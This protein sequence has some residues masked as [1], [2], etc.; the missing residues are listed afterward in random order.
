MKKINTKIEGVFVIE[1]RVFE[2]PRGFFM[3]S[4]NKEKFAELIGEPVDFVQDNHSRSSYGVLRGL[5]Y[6]KPPMAQA[7]LIRVTRGEVLDVIVD[8]RQSSPT[9]GAVDS[10]RISETNKQMVYMPRGVAHGFVV[11][12]QDVEFMYKVDNYYS[13]GHEGGIIWNDPSLSIDWIIPESDIILSDK[14]KI[15][16][17]FAPSKIIFD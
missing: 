17:K 4:F 11:L 1:P 7:K 6:Q 10:F 9:F 13:P 12:S 2:D 15:L 16:P 5:H 14:D 8:I 3:E